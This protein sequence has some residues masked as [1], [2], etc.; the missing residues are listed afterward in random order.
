[1]DYNY[2]EPWDVIITESRPAI[3]SVRYTRQ[4]R[5]PWGVT[6]ENNLTE[7]E[8]VLYTQQLL[9]RGY[10]QSGSFS[11][12]DGGL[13]NIWE[14][15]CTYHGDASL[16]RIRVLPTG[17]KYEYYKEEYQF[18]NN[19]LGDRAWNLFRKY[20]LLLKIGRRQRIRAKAYGSAR[21]RTAS[22]RKV[23]QNEAMCGIRSV[24]R[25]R[26]RTLHTLCQEFGVDP[27]EMSDTERL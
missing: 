18:A 21:E 26:R 8:M 12:G 19:P 1:M 20:Y 2:P 14:R 13:L 10:E 23:D 11:T 15:G 24:D 17:D 6:Y 4:S 9:G 7:Q 22:E 27:Q 16:A 25:D 3:T 5:E